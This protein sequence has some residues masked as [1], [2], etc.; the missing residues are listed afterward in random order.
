MKLKIWLNLLISLAFI[1][2]ISACFAKDN[3]IKI[4]KFDNG[5]T[6]VI[7]EIH[8]NP[9]VMLDTWVKTGSVNENDVNNGVAHFLEHLF[10]KGTKCHKR[11]EF[12]KILESKGGVFNAATSKDFTH[13]Y[14]KIASN[15]FDT[16]LELQ[17]DMLL[18]VAIPQNEL[19]MERKVVQE[20]IRR[21]KDE[22]TDVLYDNLN[23]ILFS[24]HPYKRETLGTEQIIGSI[25][26]DKIFEFHDKWYTPSNMTTVIVGD[27]DA[28]K[29]L[30][31]IKKKFLACNCPPQSS[32]T[33]VSKY[34]KEPF[35]TKVTKKVEKGKYNTGYLMIGFKTTDIK[36]KKDI[37]ALDLAS[38]IFGDGRTSRLY[39]SIKEQ[40]HLATSISASNFSMRD[41]GIF[42]IAATF[43]PKN[44]D[45]L[46]K[47]VV[48]ELHKFTSS[49]VTEEELNRAKTL[50]ERS[51]I[52]SNESVGS[53]AG[54]IG[55]DMTVG[56][57][58][59]YYSDYLDDINKITPDDIYQ[60][61][62]KYIKDNK[63][64][65]S[66]V[67]P[68]STDQNLKPVNNIIP[69]NTL[70]STTKGV[71]QFS[72]NNGIDLILDPNRYNDIVSLSVLVK[73]GN[74]IEPIPGLSTVIAGTLLKGTTSKN[75][76]E[77]AKELE[78]SG[79]EISPSPSD[80][81][82]E[83]SFKSTKADFDKAFDILEDIMKHPTFPQEY[84]DKVKKDILSSIEVM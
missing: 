40:K 24:H 72:L 9:I 62:N 70:K 10:F 19:D 65:I 59:S 25:S 51:F 80:N 27:V 15:Y 79:I 52:Y 32:Q 30:P 11:G 81:Y 50:M 69:V 13:Y 6:V 42:Y 20:E 45:E 8:S 68:E 38:M 58:I 1:L 73:G 2:N 76:L 53:V 71:E 56:G 48:Q 7:K 22:P 3:D 47:S 43:E 44:Y 26:R 35:I 84:I 4:F 29:I 78:N 37:Y 55:Y 23:S 5:Y 64:A 34:P 39:Q 63:M 31:L 16:A 21:S 60:A 54:S 67:L 33:V 74:Y 28:E 61:V 46:Y 18:N 36:N 57:D 77:I 41:D 75:S 83:I 12:E 17:S 82:F 66:V 14:I 49:K